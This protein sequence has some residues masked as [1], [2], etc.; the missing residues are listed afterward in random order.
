MDT[1]KT[2]WTL[3]VPYFSNIE[4]QAAATPGTVKESGASAPGPVG[5]ESCP[6]DLKNSGVAFKD[7][8]PC[9]LK[10]RKSPVPAS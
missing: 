10:D 2:S 9:P 5:I 8:G 7:A 4:K 1:D 3:L 6:R